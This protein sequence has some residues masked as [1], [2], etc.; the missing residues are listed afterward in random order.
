MS[1]PIVIVDY[2]PRWPF[3]YEE[4][5]RHI[6]AIAGHKILCLEHIGS[7]AIVGLGAKPIVDIIAGVNNSSEADGLVS[8]LSKIGYKEVIQQSG[9]LEWYYCL[10]K[11]IKGQGMWLQNFH[12]HIMK[13]RSETWDKHIL[14]RD[15]LRTHSEAAQKYDKLRRMLA[16]KY[17]YNRKNYTEAKTE[18]ISFVVTQSKEK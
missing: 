18:F 3:I 9:N 4:E 6:L 14:F 11:A 5:K 12:L 16:A 7:T 15:F 10:R 13:F 17:A 2:D 8:L 1:C